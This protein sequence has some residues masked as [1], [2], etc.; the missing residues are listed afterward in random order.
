MKNYCTNSRGFL[1]LNHINI[2]VIQLW[3]DL[4]SSLVI[5]TWSLSSCFVFVLTINSNMSKSGLCFICSLALKLRTQSFHKTPDTRIK[6]ASTAWGNTESDGC[7]IHFIKSLFKQHHRSMTRALTMWN[8]GNSLVLAQL[9]GFWVS[10]VLPGS[11][12][13]FNNPL[14]P[15]AHKCQDTSWLVSCEESSDCSK[16]HWDYSE[17][18]Q[19]HCIL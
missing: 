3:D 14:K 10:A 9:R 1:C 4:Q 6:R 2:Q 5:F 11:A 19:H 15:A 18:N 16:C 13:S 8:V 7:A 17:S 12:V